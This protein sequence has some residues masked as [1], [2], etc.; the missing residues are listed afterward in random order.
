[1]DRRQCLEFAVGSIAAV[2]GPAFTEVDTFPTRVR[3]PDEPLML[4]DRILRVEGAPRSV[5]AGRVVTEHDIQAGAWYL[6][7]GRIPPCIAIE[8]GQADLFLSG[9]L[10]IDFQTRG[11]AVYRL[12]DAQVTF[13]RGLPGPGTTI[14]YDIHIDHFFRQDQTYLF[15]FR[16]EGT[17][18]GEPLLSMTNG[19]AGFFTAAELAAGKGVVRPGIDRQPRRGTLPPGWRLPV[20]MTR[21]RYDEWQL[22]ALRRGDLGGCF[23]DAF[24]GRTLAASLRPPGGRMKLVDR[25]ADLDPE[26]G[27]F[28]LGVIRAEADIRPD[29]WFLTCHFVDDRVMPGTLMYECCLQTVRIFLLRLGWIATDG[30]VVCDPVPGVPSRLKCRGQV[31]E[32]TRVVTYEVHVKQ[33][34]YRPAAFVIADALMYADGK[35]IVDIT[36]M[37]LQLT[38]LTQ[39]A[40][41][42][43]WRTP[44]KPARFD[45]RR[46]LAFAVG[47]PS[48][49]FGE[50]YRPFD[51][52]R[53]IARLPGPPYQFIDRVTEIHAEPWKLAA[54][55]VVEAQYD[56]PPDAWYFAAERHPVMPFAV[57]LEVALQPCGW[58]AAFM[59]A[60]LT[61]PD[62]LCFRNLGGKAVQ[63]ATVT[64]TTGTLTTTARATKVGKSAGMVI[65][66]FEFT[67]RDA[68]QV[69]YQGETYFGFFTR[70]ALAQQAGVRDAAPYTPTDAERTRGRAFDYPEGPPFPEKMLRMVDRIDLF[71][72][73]GGP[74]GLGFVA[75]SKAVDPAEWF[76]TAH[77][78]QDPVWPGSLGV[79]AFLQLLKVAAVERWGH[80]PG[81]PATGAPPAPALALGASEKTAHS[82]VYRGQVIPTSRRVDVQAIITQV[83]DDRRTFLADGWLSVDGLVIYQLTN[84][85]LV[86]GVPAPSG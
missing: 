45:K 58:F 48:E 68:R 8:S 70:A 83:D 57:L 18:N 56:V 7:G 25:V 9:Y 35:P 20:P 3:L 6:D 72:T 59:G 73:D 5:T 74:H 39:E 75:G 11:L 61:S 64:P 1:M 49:A 14:R 36:D 41:A 67:V 69:V 52:G 50:P 51:E 60:A 34:G 4:V 21:D 55:S 46:L 24:A 81:A 2:L 53:F 29:A 85:A 47:K 78:Y 44:G 82:W 80:Q 30:A 65:H 28:G 27:R 86:W 17:V 76:F 10:G 33:L 32:T 66:H 54:G 79:E 13:H 22:D 31:T 26:G 42:A 19:I 63:S 12:L 84:F 37:T 43:A 62:D 16:F 38:G 23:G 15:R 77:F 40:V 71:V